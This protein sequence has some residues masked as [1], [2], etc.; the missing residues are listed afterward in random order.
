[1]AYLT[2]RIFEGSPPQTLNISNTDTNT[3]L[4]TSS[5]SGKTYLRTGT[6]DT[7]ITL[8]ADPDDGWWGMFATEQSGGT[9]GIKVALAGSDT[10]ANASGTTGRTSCNSAVAGSHCI[11][12]YLGSNIWMRDGLGPWTIA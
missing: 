7:V 1:M 9:L 10:F 4:T 2:N 3:T 8:P 12:I 6:S 11:F 5:A